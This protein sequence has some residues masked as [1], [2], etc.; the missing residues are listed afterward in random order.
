MSCILLPA[1][2]LAEPL[3]ETGDHDD[4][5]LGVGLADLVPAVVA[6][7]LGEGCGAPPPPP[8]PPPLTPLRAAEEEEGGLFFLSASA[9]ASSCSSSSSSLP[10]A[11]AVSFLVFSLVLFLEGSVNGLRCSMRARGRGRRRRRRRKEN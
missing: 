5:G 7:R 1:A 11:T 6:L 2:L 4:G 9:A 8:P 3:A 10:V